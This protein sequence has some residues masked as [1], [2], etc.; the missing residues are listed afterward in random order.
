MNAQ[1]YYLT[2]ITLRKQ[3]KRRLKAALK[4]LSRNG[5]VWSESELLRRLAKMYLGAWRGKKEKPTCLRRY[6]VSF[7][8]KRY[9]RVSWYIQ[10]VLHA[11][12]TER[13]DHSRESVSRM[14]DFAIRVYTPQLLEEVLRE[15]PAKHCRGMKNARYWQLR[16]ERRKKSLPQIFITYECKTWEHSTR[17]LRYEQSYTIIP[18]QQLTPDTLN[19]LARMAA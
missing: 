7:K 18:Q 13:S 10:E 8:G 14:M 12:L 17:G 11:I 19:N 16:W 3:S 6:N 15:P 5:I 2:S 4:I 1:K 9:V